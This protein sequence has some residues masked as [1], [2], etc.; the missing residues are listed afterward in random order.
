MKVRYQQSRMVETVES[1]NE[2]VI[3]HVE[4]FMITHI[5]ETGALLWR[6]LESPRTFDELVE[7]LQMNFDVSEEN[8][9][10]DV[11]DFLREMI[12][13]GLVITLHN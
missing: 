13:A 10:S 9:K 12:E 6:Y 7:Q 2:S 5:N 4:D 3:L 1:D 11:G 8:V